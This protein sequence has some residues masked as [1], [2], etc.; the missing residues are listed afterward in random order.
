MD[1][2][3]HGLT[4]TSDWTASGP[5]GTLSESSWFILEVQFILDVHR[6]R[7]FDGV[8]DEDTELDELIGLSI[9]PTTHD[10][11]RRS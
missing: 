2:M 10:K 3:N 11:G 5:C 8:D 9:C 7:F 4:K 6:V 1:A